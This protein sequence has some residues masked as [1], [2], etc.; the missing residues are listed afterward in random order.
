MEN[1]YV[2]KE[3]MCILGVTAA[4]VCNL[5]YDSWSQLSNVRTI[6]VAFGEMTR[7][8]KT[9]TPSKWACF[10]SKCQISDSVCSVWTCT[11]LPVQ[12]GVVKQGRG[13]VCEVEQC[14]KGVNG[15]WSRER[16]CFSFLGKWATWL[17]YPRKCS[18][19][20]KKPREQENC[21]DQ[22]KTTR[23]RK[24]AGAKKK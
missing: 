11:W 15:A 12:A 3:Q 5:I 16:M 20:T 1:C 6:G 13:S 4:V 14:R 7:V 19:H 2:Y 10:I 17:R 18:S 21:Q 9:N 8:F 23:H 22:P 24:E